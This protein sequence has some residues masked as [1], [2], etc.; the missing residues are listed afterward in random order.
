MDQLAVAIRSCFNSHDCS[1]LWSKLMH[2]D[3]LGRSF[4]IWTLAQLFKKQV[5]FAIDLRRRDALNSQ[6]EL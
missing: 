3:F 6:V 5:R 2:L 4:H 1:E